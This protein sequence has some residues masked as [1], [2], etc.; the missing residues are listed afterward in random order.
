[1]SGQGIAPR[2]LYGIVGKPLGHSISPALHNWGFCRAGYPGVYL[3]WE[4]DAEELPDF[5]RTVR[6]LPLAG[7]SVTIP[8]KRAV[9]PFLDSLTATAARAGAV[10]TVYRAQDRLVGDNS[11]VHGFLAP[12]LRRAG[13]EKTLPRRV[14]LLGAGGVCRA[15]LAA[16]SSLPEQPGPDSGME[17]YVAARDPGKAAALADDF[18]CTLVAWSELDQL[19]RH[20]SPELL[21]NATPL[22]MSGAQAGKSPMNEELWRLLARSA[23][24]NAAKGRLPLAYD[25]VYTPEDTPFLREA[26]AH[27]LACLGG[28]E[29]FAA[30]AGCQFRLWTGLELP[31]HELEARARALLTQAG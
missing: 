29:F 8:H 13:S 15:A 3:A 17:L 27:G 26:A 28:L 5:F 19:L 11:D 24:R 1:M 4:K 20:F 31:Q 21:V 23:A 16:L 7:L 2:Y 12:L 6:S 25:L 14:L 9:L 10:N 22:G 18:S 30:Q